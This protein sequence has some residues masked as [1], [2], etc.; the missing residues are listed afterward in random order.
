MD[1]REFYAGCNTVEDFEDARRRLNP[2]MLCDLCPELA[3]EYLE[4]MNI[5]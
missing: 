1:I 2:W 5:R 4:R 3:S